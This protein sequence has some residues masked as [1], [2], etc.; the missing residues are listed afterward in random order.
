MSNLI[1]E[2][3]IDDRYSLPEAELLEMLLQESALRHRHLC[4][5]QVL[6]V[7]IGLTGLRYLGLYANVGA[8]RFRNKNKRILTIAETDGCGSDG[9]AVATDCA[10]GH[11]TL[12]VVDYGKVAATLVDT[13]SKQAVRIAPSLDAREL[14]LSYYPEGQSPWHKYLRGYQLVPEE[15]L[16]KVEAV[17]LTRDIDEILSKPGLRVICDLCQEEIM[18]EREV[19][20]GGQVL[21][22][23]CAG[24]RYY[25][26]NPDP[27]G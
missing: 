15:L 17:E 11:R 26:I 13:Q 5:R 1:R 9:I 12:R 18:N 21:C 3:E 4:P 25:Q 16:L 2:Q 19:L 20:K 8:S 27:Y 10:V 22:L 23:S 14:A 7:R 24:D 6:G